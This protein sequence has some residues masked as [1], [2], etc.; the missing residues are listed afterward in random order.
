MLLALEYIKLGSGGT[1]PAMLLIELKTREIDAFKDEIVVNKSA[2]LTHTSASQFVGQYD[3]L[4]KLHSAGHVSG[5]VY[6]SLH[7]RW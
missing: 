1:E 3:V 4:I 5:Q 2:Q 7:V 6:L